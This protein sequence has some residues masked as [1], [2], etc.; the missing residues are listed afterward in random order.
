MQYES[1]DDTTTEPEQGGRRASALRLPSIPEGDEEEAMFQEFTEE[2]EDLPDAV[3][4]IPPHPIICM[5][6]CTAMLTDAE[7]QEVQQDWYPK[8]FIHHKQSVLHTLPMSPTSQ[9]TGSLYTNILLSAAGRDNIGEFVEIEIAKHMAFLAGFEQHEIPEGHHACIR[10]YK[11][12]AAKRPV[13]VKD[14][15]LLQKWETEKY[16]KEVSVATS[17]ELQI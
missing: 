13:V 11:S 1:R 8:D 16:S 10:V 14:D 5:P 3:V 17:K 2:L 9:E 7:D 15:D 4:A 12:V 6:T